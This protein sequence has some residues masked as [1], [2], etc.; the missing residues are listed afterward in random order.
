[1]QRK[2]KIAIV[3]LGSIGKRH[4]INIHKVLKKRN[5]L[6]SIDVIR[7]KESKP[8]GES[9]KNLINSVYIDFEKIPNHYDAIFITNPTHLHYYTIKKYMS[10]TKNM[11]IEKPVFDDISIDLENLFFDS[12]G[13]YY[14]A[15]PLRYTKVIQYIK[16]NIDLDKVYSA[17]A[18]CSSYLPEWRLGVDY[19]NTYSA[20]RKQGGGVSI[21][22]IHEWDY[23]MY[24]FGKPIDVKNFRGHYSHLEI[25]SDDISVYIAKYKNK[26][27]EVHL[28][29]FGQ[30]PIRKFQLFTVN[31]TISVDILNS[32]IS[33]LKDGRT[34]KFNEERN[35][36]Q[37]EE[38]KNFFDVIEGKKENENNIETALK[39]LKI[40]KEGRV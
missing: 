23:L 5:I 39:T 19:R 22:L 4:L 12:E 11:F 27:I 33:F 32:Q 24:L 30:K 3:G 14:V 6:F 21:D 31:D 36:Y 9:L 7:R 15:C 13:V 1:M 29:Y 8:L 10:K 16:N 18:I 25:D 37:V 2:Y 38:I 35:A 17:R 40:A 26:I 20:D 28:D 34:L